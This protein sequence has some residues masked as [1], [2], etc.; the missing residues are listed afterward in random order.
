VSFSPV[1]PRSVAILVLA[2]VSSMKPVVQVRY[3]RD[4][5]PTMGA[6]ARQIEQTKSKVALLGRLYRVNISDGSYRQLSYQTISCDHGGR[7]GNRGRDSPFRSRQRWLIS[8][9]NPK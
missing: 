4:T 1:T 8:R 5:V 2:Q 7:V 9:R 3:D 6:A